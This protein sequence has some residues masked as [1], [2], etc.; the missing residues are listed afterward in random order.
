MYF[1][2]VEYTNL[3]NY[4]GDCQ[5]G[6]LIPTLLFPSFTHTLVH[7]VT[8]LHA[9]LLGFLLVKN[10]VK[11]LLMPPRSFL[12]TCIFTLSKGFPKFGRWHFVKEKLT[13]PTELVFIQVT[14]L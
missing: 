12:F 13:L 2:Y 11:D 9:Q 1:L 3:S 14:Y 7:D 10:T 6:P 4:T 8:L 5:K